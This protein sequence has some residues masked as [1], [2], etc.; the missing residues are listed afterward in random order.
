MKY[1]RQSVTM[2]CLLISA[3]L[4][5]A[6][7]KEKMAERF[8][9]EA[10]LFTEQNCP[11]VLDKYTTL[12]SVKYHKADSVYGYYYSVRGELDTSSVYTAD[13]VNTF[14]ETKL[15]EVRGSIDL[16]ELKEQGLKVRYQYKSASKGLV[17]I[18]MIFGPREY[19]KQFRQ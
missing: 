16:R 5:N 7:R 3:L 1:I 15:Q 11:Q 14:T 10:D 12:D 4:F 13:L 2:I 17:Y 9:R 19:G 8:Q 18:D 6:C